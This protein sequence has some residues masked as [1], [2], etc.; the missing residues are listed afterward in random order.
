M[1]N[2][3]SDP[4]IPV[5]RQRGEDIIRPD[6]I[7]E[8]DVLRPNWP[9]AD[10]NLACYELLVGLVYLSHP[11]SK[12][13]DRPN[14]PDQ[15]QL[16]KSMKRLIPAFNLLGETPRFLQ[17]RESLEGDINQPD[18]L[19]IDSAGNSTIRK[20]QDLMVRR[21]RY[22]RLELPMA[23]MAL[24]TLQAFAPSGGKGNRTSLRGGGPMVTL[25]RPR[26]QGL[27]KMIWANVPEGEPL[28][29]NELDNLPW[30]RPCVTSESGQ[31]QAPRDTLHGG[32]DPEMFFGQPRRLR[33]I[34][35]GN[36][37]V[38]VVQR[39]Y[40]N[41]YVGW[42]HY[43]SPYYKDAQG[44]MLPRHPKPG[45][46]GYN[47]WRG[48][49]LQS[50]QGARPENLERYLQLHDEE[51]C[52]LIVSGWAMDNM[53]PMDFLWSEQPI[54]PLDTQAEN[55][56]CRMVEAAEHASY[57]LSVSVREAGQK[58]QNVQETFF[59]QTQGLFECRVSRLSRQTQSDPEGWLNDMSRT[60][61]RIFDQLA[62]P[63]LSESSE[64]RQIVGARKKLSGA[65]R[66]Y[67][68]F[69]SKMYA[70]LGLSVPAKK[71]KRKGGDHD[72]K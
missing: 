22:E 13:D 50:E 35:E 70:A 15:E 23:A 61:L 69:A 39:P 6:Q 71:P 19:F 42:K 14:P 32:P 72:G 51:R 64:R 34:N 44:Q 41:N 27:W 62:L 48:V 12:P 4:W 17:D 53:K 11:P 59:R 33:L 40:G 63:G 43:L 38:G 65:F 24:Y 60:A 54:F 68:P 57:A 9:R 26:D 52:D 2:L 3:I 10:L 1:L 21:S 8:P 58:D 46:F 45:V 56:A 47:N 5:L 31:V 55:D 67:G 18:M 30:M 66:G 29:S 28:G 25:I 49:I 7:A 20:N 37:V 16:R 36:I